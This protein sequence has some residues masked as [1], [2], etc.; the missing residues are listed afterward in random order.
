MSFSAEE[1]SLHRY[2]LCYRLRTHHWT[3]CSQLWGTSDD[4]PQW[5]HRQQTH[6]GTPVGG[7]LFIIKFNKHNLNHI[8]QINTRTMLGITFFISTVQSSRG[9]SRRIRVVFGPG[10]GGV[11]LCLCELWVWFL[12]VYGKSMYLYIVLGGYLRILVAPSVQSCCTLWISAW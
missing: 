8:L 2:Q 5:S 4:N 7:I 10:S 3:S 1:K 6:H 9:W 11:V 12:C